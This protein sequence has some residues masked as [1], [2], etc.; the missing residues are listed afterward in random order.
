MKLTPPAVAECRYGACGRVHIGECKERSGPRGGA[1]R[2]DRIEAKFVAAQQR[3]IRSGHDGRNSFDTQ[4]AL[5]D[6]ACHG[7]PGAAKPAQ[8]ES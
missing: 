7:S 4:L 1:G 8:S 5:A 2:L 3:R 6:S